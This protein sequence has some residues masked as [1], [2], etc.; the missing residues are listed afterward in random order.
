VIYVGDGH[1]VEAWFDRVRE[2]NVTEYRVRD[3][4]AP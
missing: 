3:T 2:R 4:F 1:L